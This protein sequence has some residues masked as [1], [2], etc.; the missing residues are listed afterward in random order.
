MFQEEDGKMIGVIIGAVIGG[1][2]MWYW[3]D[4]I[5]RKLDAETRSL[6]HKAADTLDAME[7]QT[8]VL[9]DKAKPQIKNTLRAGKEAIRPRENEPPTAYDSGNDTTRRAS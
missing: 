7:K 6:R 2:A 8:E 5:A 9:L 4:N 3:R 1:A